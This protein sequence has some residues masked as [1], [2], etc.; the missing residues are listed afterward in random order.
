[1]YEENNDL[2]IDQPYNYVYKLEVN[3][4][5]L[6]EKIINGGSKEDIS[7]NLKEIL[8]GDF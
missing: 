6:L 7:L 2:Y 5:E 3:N 1:M 4:R 8:K